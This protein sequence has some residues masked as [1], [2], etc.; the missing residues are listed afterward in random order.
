MITKALSDITDKIID[1]RDI[2]TFMYDVESDIEC[3]VDDGEVLELEIDNLLEA[4]EETEDEDLKIDGESDIEDL[5]SNLADLMEDKK[6]LESLLDKLEDIRNEVSE[7]EDGA[8]LIRDDIWVEYVQEL[9]EDIGDIP[10]DLPD[11]IVID[12]DLTA[13]NISQDYSTIEIDGDE[14]Y[15]RNC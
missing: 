7:F 14:Y 1:S 11:Y 4:I 9:C 15:F 2:Q 5:R 3:I 10:S 13:N 6:E 8:T 12:W